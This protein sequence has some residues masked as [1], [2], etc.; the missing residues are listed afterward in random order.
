MQTV[1]A[2]GGV[3]GVVALVALV[4]LVAVVAVVAA[5]AVVVLVL[6]PQEFYELRANHVACFANASAQRLPPNP[7]PARFRLSA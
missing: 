4:A 3:G 2:V 5:A 7:P 6:R 1:G